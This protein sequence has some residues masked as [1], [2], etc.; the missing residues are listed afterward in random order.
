VS[1]LSLSGVSVEEIA[2]LV[3]HAGTVVTG[4]VYRHQ[5]RPLLLGGAVAMDRIFPSEV[6]S[7]GEASTRRRCR[8]ARNSSGV[9]WPATSG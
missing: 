1:L 3:G 2:D 6:A 7:S 4:T 9:A 8:S 5:L